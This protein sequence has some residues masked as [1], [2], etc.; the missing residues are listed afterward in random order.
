MQSPDEVR[1]GLATRFAR[2]HRRWFALRPQSDGEWPLALSLGRPTEQDFVA[3]PARVRQWVASWET[4]GPVPAG[5]RIEWGDRYWPRLGR[6][7]LP[8]RLLVDS[9]DA[10]A[11]LLGVGCRWQRACERVG[12]LSTVWPVLSGHAVFG[13]VFD[14]L[15]DY[16]DDDFDRLLA[17]LAWTDANPASDLYLRQLPVAGL[18]TKWIAGRSVVCTELLRSLRP[19]QGELCEG[20]D[21]HALLGLKRSSPRI[22]VRLLC[23]ALRRRVG[24]LEDI[25][26]PVAQLAALDIAPRTVLIV[27]NLESGLALTDMVGVVAVMK[28]GAAVKLVAEL[29]WVTR[30][31]CFYWGDIDTFGFEILNRARGVLP[32]LQSVLMDSKT[33]LDHRS[34]CV[35]EQTQVACL[36]LP[37]LTIEEREVFEGLRIDRWGERLRLEQERI[38][39]ATALSRLFAATERI[40]TA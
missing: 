20:S 38:P 26:V 2:Q 12:R 17:L 39:W 22:R 4:C 11:T 36:E 40:C 31:H 23:P 30:A 29:P 5:V 32:H 6:Q 35:N 37:L 27:E 15:A 18:D 10:V 7:R 34:L 9:A 13:R 16:A 3:D 24:G 28:L 14:A 8:E 1:Q 33:L 19:A 21:L 25:E